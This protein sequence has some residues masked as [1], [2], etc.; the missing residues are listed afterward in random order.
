MKNTLYVSMVEM[1]VWA[2]RMKSRPK[3]AVAQVAAMVLLSI[4]CAYAAP[5]VTEQNVIEATTTNPLTNPN[6]Q[7][8]FG[9]SQAPEKGDAKAEAAAPAKAGEAAPAKEA[10]PQAPATPEP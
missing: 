9:A 4:F 5:E 2:K 8:N 3:T 7:Q 1:R 6:T 10:A